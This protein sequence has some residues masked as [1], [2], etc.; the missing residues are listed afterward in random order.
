MIRDVMVHLDGSPEDEIRLEYGQALASGEEA[1]LI[2]IFTNLL[3]E[4][5]IAMPFDG[6]AAA[7]VQVVAELEEQARKEGAATAKRLKDRLS[8][9]QGKAELRRFDETFGSMSIKVAEQARYADLF[10]ATRPYGAGDTPVWLDLIESVL[11][12]SGRGLL[13]IPPG[14]RQQGPVRSVLMA[15]N[16]SREAAR[17]LGEGL[18]LVEKADRTVVLMIDPKPDAAMESE[19]K[20]HLSRHG[21]APEIVS[22]ESHGRQVADVVLDE[23]GRASADLVIMGGYGHTRLREQVFGGATL[24]MLTISDRPILLAH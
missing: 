18:S 19:I 20:A 6:G 3:P 21:V 12:G 11:F 10:V 16:G 23:A 22:V 17:A 14:Y 5:S 8:G 9:I 24:D 15:W 13:I 1:H 7:V 4:L 2:G